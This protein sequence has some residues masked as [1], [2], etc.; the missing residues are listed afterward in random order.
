MRAGIASRIAKVVVW[1]ESALFWGLRRLT[2][3]GARLV[4]VIARFCERLDIRG[5]VDRTVPV[6]EVAIATHGELIEAM[7]ATG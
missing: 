7:I 6:R 1:R 2:R 5:I 3:Q 4:A